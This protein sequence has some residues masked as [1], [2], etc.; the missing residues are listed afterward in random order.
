MSTTVSPV[1]SCH[2]LQKKFFSCNETIQDPLS[3]LH[4]IQYSINY[5]HG[6]AVHYS[7]KTVFIYFITEN[8][9]LFTPSP[10][11]REENSW[12]YE[13]KP[14]VWGWAWGRGASWRGRGSVPGR[15]G[16]VPVWRTGR[17]CASVLNIL[18]LSFP[19]IAP[20]PSSGGSVESFLLHNL[21]WRQGRRGRKRRG[22]VRRK[23]ESKLRWTL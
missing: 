6:H 21:R 12:P 20:F 15:G 22:R 16:G 11:R 19:S 18:V 5:S 8:L 7:P 3:Y 17:D 9:Y 23:V 4:S 13:V 10:I 1:N 14:W 2:Q